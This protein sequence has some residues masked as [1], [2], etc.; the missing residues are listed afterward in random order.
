MLMFFLLLGAQIV[1]PVVLIVAHGWVRPA[2]AAGFWLRVLALLLL[3]ALLAMVGF[4]A[5]PP[6][7]TPHVLA[8]L[9]V[10]ASLI[11]ARRLRHRSRLAGRARRWSEAGLAGALVL[12]VGLQLPAALAGR[13]MP[14][15]SVDIAFPLEAGRYLVVNGGHH[16][17]LNAHFMTLDN[18]DY[19]D[20][21]GQSYAVDLIGIDR[22]GW[23]ATSFLGGTDPA[24]YLIFGAR[25]LAPCDGV[26][27]GAEAAMPDLP[28]PERD[29]ERLEGNHLLVDCGD[30]IVLLAHLRQGSLAVGEG[31]RVSARQ[32]VA[33]VGNSGQSG[34]PHLHVH[35]Q[36]GTSPDAPL[37][38]EPLP[39]S[40]D[41]VFAVR[42]ARLQGG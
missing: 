14:E 37:Q 27:I 15:G 35:A 10:L 17:M 19:A 8:G 11:A 26:V 30:F 4:W 34:E 3:C 5:L 7:Y 31:D 32:V 39:V 28:V 42:N 1:V 24:D 18:P 40:F 20:Y 29:T 12:L 2:S 9:T 23:R 38:G 36:H 16:A 41:G 21:R 33:E 25:V 13:Q 22:R 6:W